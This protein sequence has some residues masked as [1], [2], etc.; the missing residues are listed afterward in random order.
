MSTASTS[1][2]SRPATRSAT[3]LPPGTPGWVAE[4]FRGYREALARMTQPE[5]LAELARI[6]GQLELQSR[7][8]VTSATLLPLS[9]WISS[10][11]QLVL[12]SSPTARP[13]PSPRDR[14]RAASQPS[15]QPSPVDRLLSSSPAPRVA[16]KLVASALRSSR[17]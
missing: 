8:L 12:R 2:A 1:R 7:N 10:L 14:G 16:A 5:L 9:G 6:N 13:S 17:R 3:P 11:D 4:S 15:P